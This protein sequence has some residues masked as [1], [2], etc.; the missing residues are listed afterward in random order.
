MGHDV[1]Y[2]SRQKW[3]WRIANIR[4]DDRIVT[5]E[6]NVS[7]ILET[8]QS[9]DAA[10]TTTNPHQ[11]SGAQPSTQDGSLGTAASPLTA[12]IG[13]QSEPGQIKRMK[14]REI[15]AL[16]ELYLSFCADQPML[17]FP[18]EGFIESLSERN[19]ATLFAIIANSLPYAQDAGSSSSSSSRKDSQAFREA[20]QSLVMEH[21][22]RGDVRLHTLQSLCLI[23]FFDFR[24]ELQIQLLRDFMC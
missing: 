1:G 5:L 2:C 19:D 16:G 12:L 9:T 7:K 6:S 15:E 4:Q 8:L 14:K 21:I 22:A 11:S 13:D 24:S 18:R 10:S 17:L 23:V 3:I 20:A